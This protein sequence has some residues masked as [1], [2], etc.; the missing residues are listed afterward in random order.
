MKNMFCFL[1]A[2]HG[3]GKFCEM[4][5][6]VAGNSLPVTCEKFRISYRV[7]LFYW[8]HRLTANIKQSCCHIDSTYRNALLKSWVGP[9]NVCETKPMIDYWI[10]FFSSS[11]GEKFFSFSFFLFWSFF[12]WNL[13]WA[14]QP[15]FLWPFWWRLFFLF[16][17]FFDKTRERL[18]T[19]FENW[20]EKDFK[21]KFDWR[22]IPK[23]FHFNKF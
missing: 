14:V 18:E 3:D 20:I 11:F 19:N 4:D 1:N 10:T 2:F 17:T 12:F 15:I 23:L 5:R 7:L 22:I 16:M 6:L 8:N 21:G 13:L 9:L